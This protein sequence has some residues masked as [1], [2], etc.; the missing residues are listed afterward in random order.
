LADKLQAFKKGRA[1]GTSLADTMKGMMGD[2]GVF[3]QMGEEAAK[4]AEEH[5]LR[6]KAQRKKRTKAGKKKAVKEGGSRRPGRPVG[7]K[8]KKKKDKKEEEDSSGEEKLD[9]KQVQ[10]KKKK[11]KLKKKKEE[12][13]G[14]KRPQRRSTKNQNYAESYGSDAE[15]K[16]S[17][18]DALASDASPSDR[19]VSSSSDSS[20]EDSGLGEVSEMEDPSVTHVMLDPTLSE[21]KKGDTVVWRATVADDMEPSTI[22]ATIMNI[23][24]RNGVSR[25]KGYM[26]AIYLKAEKEEELGGWWVRCVDPKTWQY[27][28]TEKHIDFETVA[29]L[30]KWQKTETVE[31]GKAKGETKMWMGDEAWKI[32]NTKLDKCYK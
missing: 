23:A 30:V 15:Y 31:A 20:N 4:F 22:L 9:Q 28:M 5:Q 29:G 14:V 24:K 8:N 10:R 16:G 2:A 25:K 12:E 18:S 19:A 1:S 7:S 21:L 26:Q 13:S 32:I 3:E 17:D 11:K 6:R 27:M